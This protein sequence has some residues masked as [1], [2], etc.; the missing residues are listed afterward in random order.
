MSV[1]M[2]MCVTSNESACVRAV[3]SVCQ[4]ERDVVLELMCHAIERMSWCVRANELMLL[5]HFQLKNCVVW[6]LI[7][8]FKVIS[9]KD[10]NVYFK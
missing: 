5:L 1:Q 3:E 2:S 10:E 9:H 6:F 8:I 7:N 4:C